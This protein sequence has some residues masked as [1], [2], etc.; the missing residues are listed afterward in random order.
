MRAAALAFAVAFV[1][2]ATDGLTG[3]GDRFNGL[4]VLAWVAAFCGV[5]LYAVAESLALERD[6]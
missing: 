2:V 6:Q 3:G 5:V 4:D 1:L